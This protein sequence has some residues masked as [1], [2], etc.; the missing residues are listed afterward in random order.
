MLYLYLLLTFLCSYIEGMYFTSCIW[1]NYILSISC[2]TTD[3]SYMLS[4][5]QFKFSMLTITYY[6]I[7]STSISNFLHLVEPIIY[8]FHFSFYYAVLPH[9]F[10]QCHPTYQRQIIGTIQIIGQIR[11]LWGQLGNFIYY[12]LSC[13]VSIE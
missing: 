7:C 11:Y 10:M 13:V 9:N 12:P 8:L 4:S 1:L 3:F 6:F 2:L 5:L